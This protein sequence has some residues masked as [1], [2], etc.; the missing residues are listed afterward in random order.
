M[1]FRYGSSYSH[2]DHECLVTFFGGQTIYNPRG[3]P[4]F[5]RKRMAVEGEIIATGPAAISARMSEIAAAY[6]VDGGTAE[7]L[8]SGG[9]STHYVLSSLGSVSGVRVVQPPSFSQQDGKAHMATGLPFSIVLEADYLIGDGD[10]LVSYSETIA[11]VGDG[12]P[13]HVI[14][15]LDS[16]S[17]IEQ[18]VSTHTPVTILQS[19]EA[20]GILSYPAPNPPLF[21]DSLDRPDGIQISRSAPRL[22]GATHVDWPVRWQYRMTGSYLP[23]IPDPLLR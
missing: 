23:T 19:G 20:V 15:E 12:G 22:D 9:A 5:L 6:A 13:R 21:P 4:Q 16:G 8:T 2:P 18:F 14:L 3:R 10:G 7:L 1:I 11:Y 17:P